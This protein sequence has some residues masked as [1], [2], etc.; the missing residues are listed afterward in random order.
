[1]FIWLSLRW[2][3]SAGWQWAWE[4]SVGQRVQWCVETFSLG[5]LVRT[6]FAPFKQT[7]AGQAKGSIGDFFRALV[8]KT[9]SRVIGFF[10]RSFLIGIA[11]GC[12]VFVFITGLLLLLLW[13]FI[14]LTPILAVVLLGIG[15][16]K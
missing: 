15:V 8:D 14:P 13:P 3:Y 16:G 11:L 12:I 2:W 4:R 9:I 10:V 6:L 5:T 7:F 1:M